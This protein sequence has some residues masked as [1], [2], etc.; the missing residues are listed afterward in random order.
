M[1]PVLKG[2]P[3]PKRECFSWELH[4]RRFIQAVRFGDWKAVRN[5]AGAPLELYDLKADPGESKNVAVE[6]PDLVAKAE[7]LLKT[8]RTADPKWPIK[9][10]PAGKRG[11]KKGRK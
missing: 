2:G 3:A 10:A 4:E 1:V 8:S 5:G 9:A 6:K 7:E 11:R